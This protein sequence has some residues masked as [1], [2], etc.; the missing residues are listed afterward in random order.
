MKIFDLI[1]KGMMTTEIDEEPEL[2]VLGAWN[3]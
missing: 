2:H 3:S 1:Q